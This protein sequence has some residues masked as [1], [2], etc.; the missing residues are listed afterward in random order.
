MRVG[1]VRGLMTNFPIWKISVDSV[2][3]LWQNSTRS[4]IA[5]RGAP[6][7]SSQSTSDP[8]DKLLRVLEL[9]LGSHP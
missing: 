9:G 8:G 3:L 2:T 1:A 6:S 4:R 7:F 5:I